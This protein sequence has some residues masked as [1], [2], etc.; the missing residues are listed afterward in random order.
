MD[1]LR[2]FIEKTKDSLR[3]GQTERE[4]HDSERAYAG[5]PLHCHCR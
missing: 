4:Y 3:L 5:E 1:T 2:N